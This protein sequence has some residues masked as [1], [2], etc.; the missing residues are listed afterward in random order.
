MKNIATKDTVAISNIGSASTTNNFSTLSFC[1]EKFN[2]QVEHN[3]E[4]AIFAGTST[5]DVLP[6]ILNPNFPIREKMLIDAVNNRTRERNYFRLY[7]KL[8]EKYISEEEFDEELDKHPLLYI[9]PMNIIPN[10]L[11]FLEAFKLAPHIMDADS[12]GSLE[13]LFSFDENVFDTLCTEI[14]DGIF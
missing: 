10:K 6:Q 13:A 14:N 2:L 11:N 5:V 1:G 7:C 9:N 3:N 4:T 12:I 8:L